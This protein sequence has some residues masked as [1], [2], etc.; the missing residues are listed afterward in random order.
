MPDGSVLPPLLPLSNGRRLDAAARQVLDPAGHPVALRP[1][2]VAVLEALLR[3][4]GRVV[5]TDEL[6]D[7]VWGQAAVTPDN[8]TQSIG[9]IRRAIGDPGGRLLRTVRGR[10]YLLDAR[11][12]AGPAQLAVMPFTGCGGAQ[13]AAEVAVGLC[14]RAGLRVPDAP[15]P[16]TRADW[17]LA[18]SL[19]REGSRLRATVRLAAG[20]DAALP[21]GG[22]CDSDAAPHGRLAAEDAL[23]ARIV[24]G[25]AG[26]LAGP[27]DPPLR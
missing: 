14:H 23:V 1:R 10:G 15:P 13:F 6:L 11:G 22:R 4:R 9:E 20:A 19:R 7:V 12:P 21:G 2:S 8:V 5:P 18:G 17:L 16:G 3:R 27:A 24:E 26:A 25:V